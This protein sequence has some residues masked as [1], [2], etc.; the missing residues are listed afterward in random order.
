MN[1]FKPS[2]PYCH[3]ELED[4]PFPLTEKGTGVCTAGGGAM[5]YEIELD[6]TAIVVDKFGK[7]SKKKGWKVSGNKH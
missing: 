5:D 6:D 4:L 1:T 7:V 3:A 2:C